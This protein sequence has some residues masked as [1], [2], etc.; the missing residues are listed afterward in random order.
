MVKLG[1]MR[2]GVRVVVHRYDEKIIRFPKTARATPP[3]ELHFFPGLRKLAV[4]GGWRP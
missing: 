2:K 3:Y 4:V 1:Y